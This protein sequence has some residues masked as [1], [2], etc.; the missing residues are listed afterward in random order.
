MTDLLEPIKRELSERLSS[1]LLGGFALS[2]VL[3]NYK[4]L[5]IL[6]SNNTVSTTFS[7]VEKHCFGTPLD[8]AV[9]GFLLPA[10]TTLAYIYLYPF[11]AEIIY[12]RAQLNNKRLKEIKGTIEEETPLTKEESRRIRLQLFQAGEQHAKELEAKISEIESLKDALKAASDQLKNGAPTPYSKYKE[13]PPMQQH[14]LNVIAQQRDGEIARFDLVTGIKGSPVE[15][16]FAL[17]ELM[18]DSLISGV[19][20]D[21][22]EIIAYKI[23]HKGRGNLLHAKPS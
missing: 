19:V 22:N 8:V 12:K 18:E 9:R 16:E 11:P 13:L 20:S 17:G 23:T 2:W 1:P 15:I 21:E 7:L 3:W 5:L 10:I 14:I 4:F 6:A